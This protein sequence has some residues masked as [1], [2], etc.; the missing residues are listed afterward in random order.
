MLMRPSP[1]FVTRLPGELA[2]PDLLIDKSSASQ[3][4]YK[5]S[6]QPLK[7]TGQPKA[8]DRNFFAQGLVTGFVF[9][10]L[11][12]ATGTIVGTVY[13]ARKLYSHW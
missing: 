6:L 11:P 4:W 9:L 2:L 7:T 10:V 13:I 12:V 3:D 5:Q 8:G 1:K